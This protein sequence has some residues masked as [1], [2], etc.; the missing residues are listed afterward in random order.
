MSVTAVTF[1][2]A[3]APR[4]DALVGHTYGLTARERRVTECV[5]RR[6]GPTAL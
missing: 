2:P 1:E 5:A 4:L 6:A 3:R